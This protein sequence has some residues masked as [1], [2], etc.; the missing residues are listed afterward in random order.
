MKCWGKRTSRTFS[1]W[2]PG[3]QW[4]A[5]PQDLSWHWYP[6][7]S[8]IVFEEAEQ[9]KDRGG[10]STVWCGTTAYS[11]DFTLTNGAKFPSLQDTR[12]WSKQCGFPHHA[13]STLEIQI[14]FCNSQEDSE[15][16]GI[17]WM[18]KAKKGVPKIGFV[19]LL[20]FS[21]SIS[22]CP[23]IRKLNLFPADTGSWSTGDGRSW[24]LPSLMDSVKA[25]AAM[26]FL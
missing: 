25:F 19:L 23:S 11:W 17:L 16:V 10:I 22:A 8:I 13:P 7:A 21:L 6:W 18:W 14:V 4:C 20:C 15:R 9:S 5:M 1:C 24:K 3:A 12:S 26:L 2:R